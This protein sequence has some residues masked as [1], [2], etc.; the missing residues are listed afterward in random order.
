MQIPLSKPAVLFKPLLLVTY[1]L[2]CICI[3]ANKVLSGEIN[4]V[5]QCS[6]SAQQVYESLFYSLDISVFIFRKSILL[7]L[8]VRSKE[9]GRA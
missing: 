6:L 4:I 3:K 5:H 9:V 1:M 8:A 2:I 7:P